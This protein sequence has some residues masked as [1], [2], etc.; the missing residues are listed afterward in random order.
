MPGWRTLWLGNLGSDLLIKGQG[1]T[2]TQI[3]KGK[4]SRANNCWEPRTVLHR[5]YIVPFH[6]NGEGS[7]NR[8]QRNHELPSSIVRDQNSLHAIERSAAHPHPLADLQKAVR[9]HRNLVPQQGANVFN[10]M[11]RDGNAGALDPDETCDSVGLQH[12]DPLFVRGISHAH[13]CV[14][15]KQRNFYLL[16]AV[17]PA[18]SLND[19]RQVSFYAAGVELPRGDLFVTRTGPHRVPAQIF[20]AR[21][22]SRMNTVQGRGHHR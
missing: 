5:F 3:T 10:L 19:H 21:I 6:A 20:R 9:L 2:G 22:E 4:V 8:L 14:T 12:L 18:V 7:F 11:I 13:K 17:A 15:R 1:K 16:L